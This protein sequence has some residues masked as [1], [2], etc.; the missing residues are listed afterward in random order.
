MQKCEMGVGHGIC[1]ALTGHSFVLLRGVEENISDVL[2]HMHRW[3]EVSIMLLPPKRDGSV[4]VEGDHFPMTASVP[5]RVDHWDHADKLAVVAFMDSESPDYYSQ[6]Q[7]LGRKLLRTLRTWKPIVEMAPPPVRCGL[8]V[9]SIV[10][11]TVALWH[12]LRSV[13]HVLS[14]SELA[15]MPHVGR[16]EQFTFVYAQLCAYGAE[17]LRLRSELGR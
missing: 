12:M 13:G 6:L 10:S 16:V 8:W 3:G 17:I 11:S 5:I 14:S 7:D 1:A 2:E 15:R 4:V 9:G